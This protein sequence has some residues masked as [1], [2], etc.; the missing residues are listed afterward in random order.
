[1]VL[2]DANPFDT[3][4]NTKKIHAVVVAGELLDAARL[5][6]IRQWSAVEKDNEA[7]YPRSLSKATTRFDSEP[8]LEDALLLGGYQFAKG[9]YEKA[10][11][12]Y[13]YVEEQGTG[14]VEHLDRFLL[15]V[16]LN[17]L[18]EKDSPLQ[19]RDVWDDADAVLKGLESKSELESD[20][21][22]RI[23]EAAEYRKCEKTTKRYGRQRAEG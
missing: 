5:E 12:Y 9:D 4:S 11:T 19:C 18:F 22:E 7:G 17:L 20:I 21:L 15:N 3:S 1:L 16:K 6:E 14:T 2:L 23:V 10:L 8:N 13:R